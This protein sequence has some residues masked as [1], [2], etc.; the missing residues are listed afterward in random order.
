VKSAHL[1]AAAEI[2]PNRGFRKA[3]QWV[4]RANVPWANLNFSLTVRSTVNNI[5]FMSICFHFFNAALSAT[6]Q[7]RIANLP[8][9]IHSNRS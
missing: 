5:D 1:C 2:S 4:E 9:N 7:F 8:E 6:T 3:E